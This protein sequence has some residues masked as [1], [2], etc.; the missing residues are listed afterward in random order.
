MSLIAAIDP[1]KNHTALALFER[2]HDR[3][4]EYL[5]GW[6]IPSGTY[7]DGLRYLAADVSCVVMELPQVYPGARQNDPNDLIAVAYA[8][9]VVSGYF[10]PQVLRE[11]LSP[12]AWKGQVP[13]EVTQ[14][15]LLGTL[16]QIELGR[17]ENDLQGIPC[18]LQHNLFDAIGLGLVACGRQSR[19]GR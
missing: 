11:T 16:H 1:G 5:R 7:P 13:K 4:A 12:S 2:T 17:L 3:G 14:L 9:G 15:R 18:H 6:L 19:G 8:G 10:G